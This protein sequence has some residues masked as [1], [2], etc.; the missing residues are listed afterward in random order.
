MAEK[1][2]L[3][4]K[5]APA[6]DWGK[7]TSEFSQGLMQIGA[8]R[9]Q[10]DAYFDQIQRENMKAVRETENFQT[11]DL[12]T[13]L[14]GA[15]SQ[16]V[17]NSYE[18]NRLVKSGKLNHNV[19]RNFMNNASDDWSSFATT[20]K[21][22][23]ETIV[24]GL[25][26]QQ[27]GENGL[28]AGSKYEE[29]LIERRSEL[30]NLKNRTMY[31]DPQTGK[32]FL[33]DLDETGNISD[34]NNL[35]D[36]KSLNKPMNVN[37]N[38][39]DF[40]TL[41]TDRAKNLKE[42]T[43]GEMED[44]DGKQIYVTEKG[45]V[46]NPELPGSISRVQ[47]YIK[48]TPRLVYNTLSQSDNRYESYFDPKDQEGGDYQ[49]KMNNFIEIENGA[50]RIKGEKP[51]TGEELN[52]FVADYDR[53]LMRNVTD[54]Q[55][56]YQPSPTQDQLIAIDEVVESTFMSNLG[57]SKMEAKPSKKNSSGKDS[58]SGM[59]QGDANALYKQLRNA[60]DQIETDPVQA[61]VI[62]TNQAVDGSEF[63]VKEGNLYK[64]VVENIWNKQEGRSVRTER[65]IGPIKNMQDISTS[66]FGATGGKGAGK[67]NTLYQN[68]E[69]SSGK[70]PAVIAM[71]EEQ[72]E[73]MPADQMASNQGGNF[74]QRL[75]KGILG[76]GNNQNIS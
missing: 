26:R 31:Q 22:L 51:L 7:L 50:R 24:K 4:F 68:A 71:M 33:A 3:G 55:G 49:R 12:N 20:A 29:D 35:Q 16:N 63:K 58:G 61:A 38:F 15:V 9:G 36:V 23:D 72:T 44:V 53:F 66:F 73:E 17:D 32:Y 48:K 30:L 46:M 13:L 27:P 54:G 45:Q 10:Q 75:A 65:E 39:F 74:L 34:Y 8:R 62:F 67:A 60:W 1:S 56:I 64:L 5:A 14:S 28:P 70:G 41:V 19:Y 42:Y 18:M 6:I 25:E 69:K 43:V 47:A 76:R 59:S 21:T 40:N 11:Q 37:D 57:Y 52:S 2:Y